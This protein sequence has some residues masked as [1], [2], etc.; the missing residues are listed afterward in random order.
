MELSNKKGIQSIV[1]SLAALNLKEVVIC[2]G[3]R[4]S[5]LVISF[6]RH[7]Q[8]NCTSIRDE[9]SAGFFA[10]GKAI[11]SKQPVA[12]LCTSG[13][14]SLNFAPAIV[15]AY[16]Q[17]IPLI[18]ITADRPKAWTNQGNGQTIQQTDIYKNYIRASYELKGDATSEEDIW[19]NER[20][21][22]E[23]FGIG[24][25]TDRGPIHFNVPIQEPMYGI[26]DISI[27]QPKVFQT[28][29]I[30]ASLTPNTIKSLAQ[31]FNQSTKVMILVGQYPKDLVL[32]EKLQYLAEKYH[33][34]IL[35]ESTSNI[36]HTL[37]IENI[38]RCIT[39]FSSDEVPFY[40]PDLLITIGGEVISKR[41]KSL[42]R[43]FRPQNHWNVHPYNYHMDTYQSLTH[44]IPMDAV[45]FFEQIMPHLQSL[46]KNYSA[47]WQAL[48]TQRK[49]RHDLYAKDCAYSDFSVFKAIYLHIPSDTCVHF[50]NSSAIRYAQLFDNS[51]IQ[52]TWCNRGTS[53]IDGS[54]STVY[55]AATSQ[56]SQK[57]LFITGDV[58]FHYDINALW[59]EIPLRNL[60]IIVINNGGGG[61]FRII[62][63][64]DKVAERSEF[65][66]TEMH[67]HVEKIAEH[68]NWNYCAAHDQN[69]LTTC[70]NQLFDTSTERTI[71]EIFTPAEKNPTVLAQYW[72]FLKNK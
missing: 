28:E 9:R 29:P 63:G 53:G 10:L 21:I 57:Y 36:H 32:Q 7:P 16:Y 42:L 55:G 19:F 65:L 5:S 24:I 35:T 4:N 40:M 48:S 6:N 38:D 11:A 44:A 27:S 23:G 51:A 68:F 46:K 72:D 61:I 50:A 34:I 41:I 49:Q 8:F 39:G 54:T 69:E 26:S 58:A 12:L 43:K 15:E 70:L 71:L 14:A 31:E 22:S 66:E 1:L 2:P 64:P 25:Q 60:N 37:F 52:E 47:L 33:P 17:R 62:E 20:S 59:N 18:V 67:N 56:P 45:A 3:S 13:S 30:Q